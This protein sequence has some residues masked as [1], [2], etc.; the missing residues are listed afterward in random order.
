MPPI[1]RANFGASFSTSILAPKDNSTVNGFLAISL[2]K[3]FSPKTSLL[4]VS[5]E[6]FLDFYPN[7]GSSGST[8]IF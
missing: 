7:Q 1:K 8:K 5:Y 6:D 3:Q 4:L 2:T